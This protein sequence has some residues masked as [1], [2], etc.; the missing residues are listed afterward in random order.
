MYYKVVKDGRIIDAIRDVEIVY[1]KYQ[2]RYNRFIF[3]DISEAQAIFSPDRR[4]IWHIDGLY[5]VPEC[6][7]HDCVQLEEIDVYEYEQLK[8]FDMQTIEDVIDKYTLTLIQGG[9]I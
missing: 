8:I 1:I 9:V 6:V 7:Q 5:D 2:E 4:H 3:C